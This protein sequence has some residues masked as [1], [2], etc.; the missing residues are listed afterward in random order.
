[1]ANPHAP[2][3]AGVCHPLATRCA[4]GMV[5]GVATRSLAPFGVALSRVPKGQPQTSPG[6]RPGKDSVNGGNASPERAAQGKSLP[7]RQSP[8][9]NIVHLIDGGRFALSGLDLSWGIH[10]TQ[11]V[12]LVVPH[13]FSLLWRP[14]G[15]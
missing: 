2:Q 10:P 6:Q 11:G 7:V 3:K 13:N 12:A 4:G 14:W 15:L 8:F 9:K 1:M 5:W